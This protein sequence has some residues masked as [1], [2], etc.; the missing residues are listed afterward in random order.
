MEDRASQPR[1]AQGRVGLGPPFVVDTVCAAASLPYP[2]PDA[3]PSAQMVTTKKVP[4][5]VTV[6]GAQ[7]FGAELRFASQECPSTASSPFATGRCYSVPQGF[8]WGQKSGR[9]T[10]PI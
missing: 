4:L 9:R 3:S 7:C 6:P 5:R 8:L 10:A 1:P 2:P